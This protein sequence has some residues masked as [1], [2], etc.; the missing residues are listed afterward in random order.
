MIINGMAPTSW[1]SAAKGLKLRVRL[2]KRTKAFRKLPDGK[3]ELAGELYYVEGIAH[4]W[5]DTGGGEPDM[6]KLDTARE[7]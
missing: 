6:S 4:T 3:E 5:L 2:D 1:L 7:R